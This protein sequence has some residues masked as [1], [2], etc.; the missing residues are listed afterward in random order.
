MTGLTPFQKLIASLI[1]YLALV[2]ASGGLFFWLNLRVQGSAAERE[3]IET[4]IAS[5]EEDR[6]RARQAELVFEEKKAE[7]ERLKNVFISP[8]KPVEFI[9]GLEKI[10]RGTG[11]SISLDLVSE[12]LV[13]GAFSFRISVEGTEESTAK[14]LSLLE[15]M[16]YEIAIEEFTLQRTRAAPGGREKEARLSVVINVKTLNYEIK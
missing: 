16:P 3:R 7:L 2:I 5:L 11:N 13:G 8:E 1:F 14:Y 12:K 10:A 9:E 6:R 4:E 15:L